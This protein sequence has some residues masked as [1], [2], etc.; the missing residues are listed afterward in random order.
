MEERTSPRMLGE[1]EELRAL[2]LDRIRR[3]RAFR[4]HVVATLVGSLFL[5]TVWAVTEYH[6]AGD[7]QPGWPLV[8]PGTTGIP[9]SSIR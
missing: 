4:T 6:N 8:A 3:R 2:A 9:G 7:G 5:S 1:N